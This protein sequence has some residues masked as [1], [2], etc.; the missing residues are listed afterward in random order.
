MHNE[1]CKNGLEIYWEKEKDTKTVSFFLMIKAGSN[2]EGEY[3]AGIAH[4]MEHLFFKGNAHFTAKEIAKYIEYI[5]GE[6]D[7]STSKEFISFQVVVPQKYAYE[8]MKMLVDLVARPGFEEQ[9]IGNERSVIAQEIQLY[10]DSPED[11]LLDWM[12]ASVW[13]K[14]SIARPILGTRES[15]EQI[16]RR[17][18]LAYHRDAVVGANMAFVCIGAID[19]AF[20]AD[21]KALCEDFAQGNALS[22]R[23]RPPFLGKGYAEERTFAQSYL[24]LVFPAVSQHSP[25]YWYE[26]LICNYFAR[27]MNSLLYQHLREEL[28]L[29]YDVSMYYDGFGEEGILCCQLSCA[30]E[31]LDFIVSE[32]KQIIEKISQIEVSEEEFH[33]LR[34]KVKNEILIEFDHKYSQLVLLAKSKLLFGY[35]DTY[36]NFLKSIDSLEWTTFQKLLRAKFSNN[37]PRSYFLFK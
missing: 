14:Q 28:H 26:H 27:G 33:Y 16:N 9:A 12:E 34:D 6:L 8:T 23:I 4:F 20:M 22:Y 3:P 1:T 19:E 2:Y 35:H 11:C 13:A 15:L 18:L 31:K 36:E 21:M 30:K 10:E 7:A 5:G 17:Q 37:T 24:A 32:I 25:D 29:I